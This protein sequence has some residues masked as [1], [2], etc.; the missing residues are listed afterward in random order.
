MAIPAVVRAAIWK[1]SGEVG[2]ITFF[3]EMN[4]ERDPV[5]VLLRIEN[6]SKIT[7]FSVSR[8]FVQMTDADNHLIRPVSG[9]EIVSGYLRRLRKLMP[10]NE[11]EI[12]GL[13]GEIRADFPQQKIVEVYGRMKEY[14]NHG[15]PVGWRSQVQNFLTGKQA[16]Q[17]A[18]LQ[19][20]DTLIEEIGGLAKNY[21]WPN[22]IAPDTTYTGVVF[23]DRPVKQPANIFFQVGEQFIG[24]KMILTE[25]DK[26]KPAK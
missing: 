21:L 18:Q 4:D 13:M 7:S 5:T 10:R 16:S 23:F 8:Y 26:K 24:T 14:M 11:N 20:A 3:A 19:E 15:R 1:A 6:H 12:D 2:L 25:S 9:D 22:D 17:Q